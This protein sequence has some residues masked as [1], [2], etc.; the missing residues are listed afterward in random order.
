[1]SKSE[2]RLASN[3]SKFVKGG[4]KVCDGLPL[5]AVPE[6]YEFVCERLGKKVRDLRIAAF[7]TECSAEAREELAG[8]VLSK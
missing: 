4:C 6:T 3:I 5:L 8:Y 7:Q 2:I 1:M